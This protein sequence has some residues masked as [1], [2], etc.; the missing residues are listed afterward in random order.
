MRSPQKLL[1]HVLTLID[2]VKNTDGEIIANIS[3]DPRE[4][5]L[6]FTIACLSQSQSIRKTTNYSDVDRVM[7][8]IDLPKIVQS[9]DEKSK[10]VLGD[11]RDN[12]PTTISEIT[13]RLNLSESTIS[14]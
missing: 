11:V 2:L 14:R 1:W 5:F 3:G 12:Q 8:E 4:I 6:A 10:T 9:L 13:A 7:R